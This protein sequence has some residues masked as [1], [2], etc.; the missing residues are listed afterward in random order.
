MSI[1]SIRSRL[2]LGNGC[3]QSPPKVD[4]SVFVTG[5]PPEKNKEWCCAPCYARALHGDISLKKT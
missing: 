1:E 5:G 4:Y 3:K 2:H